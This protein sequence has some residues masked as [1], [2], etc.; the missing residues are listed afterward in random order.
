MSC[1]PV[2]AELCQVTQCISGENQPEMVREPAN[3]LSSK[4]SKGRRPGKAMMEWGALLGL[5]RVSCCSQCLEPLG[6]QG[7]S[8]S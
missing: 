8:R 1:L 5:G 2:M 7:V 3:L 6:T 4:L